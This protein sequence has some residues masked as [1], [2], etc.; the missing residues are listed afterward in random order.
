MLEK[1]CDDYPIRKVSISFAGLVNNN[2]EQL[3][4][5]ENYEKVKKKENI[6][7]AIDTIKE[8]Y[9]KNSILKA[10]SLLRD[11]TARERNKKIG[12]HRA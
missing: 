12:G 3:N 2:T 9:G 5:F 8:K 7:D 4:L 6:N 11:S 1:F 10:S